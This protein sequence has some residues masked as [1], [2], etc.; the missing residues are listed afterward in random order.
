M[1]TSPE[2]PIYAISSSH[3][4]KSHLTSKLYKP[5]IRPTANTTLA[6]TQSESHHS[7]HNNESW[8]GNYPRLTNQQ[9]Q[10]HFDPM[11]SA[12][13]Q[14]TISQ[15]NKLF[16]GINMPPPSS[17]TNQIAPHQIPKKTGKRQYISYTHIQQNMVRPHAQ[18][19]KTPIYHQSKQAQHPHLLYYVQRYR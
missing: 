1:F 11:V 4:T 3:L 16:Q 7:H 15:V 10:I 6:R 8:R 13:A 18:P 5:T 19:S 17:I 12:P 14:P 2:N 9:P